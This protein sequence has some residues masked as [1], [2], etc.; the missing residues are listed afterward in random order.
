MDNAFT[1]LNISMDMIT[2]KIKIETNFS[3]RENSINNNTIK[4][5]KVIEDRDGKE[6]KKID[7]NYNFLID[8]RDIVIEL[9]DKPNV[10]TK[11]Y[12]YVSDLVDKLGR[13]LFSAYD[14][15]VATEYGVNTK[16]SIITPKDQSALKTK[17]V[18]FI[19]AISDENSENQYRF[20]ES[21]SGIAIFDEKNITTYGIRIE[22]SNDVNFYNSEYIYIDKDGIGTSSNTIKFSIIDE[23]TS[24]GQM[25]FRL[26]FDKD[27]QYYFRSRIEETKNVFGIWS[28]I[29]NVIIK[30]ESL[31]DDDE[32]YMDSMLFS[33][34]LFK[35]P[36]RQLEV[37]GR[38]EDSYTE[39]EFYIEFNKPI[40]VIIDEENKE[41]SED[42]LIYIGKGFLIRRDL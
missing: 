1:V 7:V 33:E 22:I 13:T 38:S 21:T 20:E 39:N 2:K 6:L 18:K 27:G 14:K 10:G 5:M 34:E 36:Y 31:F 29:T 12:I 24:L 26:L 30:A 9:V 37:V 4:V 28:P 35:E 25:S 15:Y 3:V 11:Y 17:D 32:N 42:G 41:V 19:I 16:A 8:K 40:K 23:S